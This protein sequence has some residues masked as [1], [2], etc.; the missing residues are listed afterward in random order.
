LGGSK[1]GLAARLPGKVLEINDTSNRAITQEQTNAL[2]REMRAQEKTQQRLIDEVRALRRGRG[3]PN[4]SS[5]AAG[6]F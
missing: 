6:G 2:T 1:S 4:G 5:N 3:L